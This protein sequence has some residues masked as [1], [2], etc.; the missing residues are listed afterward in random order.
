MRILVTGSRDWWDEDTI[1]DALNFIVG[2]VDPATV[3]IV[4]GACPTGADAIVDRLARAAGAIVEPH[5]AEWS[6]FRRA[7]GP[8][9]N[10]FMVSLGADVCLAFPMGASFGTRDCIAQAAAAGIPVRVYEGRERYAGIPIDRFDSR[11][12][13]R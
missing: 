4:H 8:K 10:G 11:V 5:P 7:A 12:R 6:R 1:A 9:R 13:S 2:S 3:T